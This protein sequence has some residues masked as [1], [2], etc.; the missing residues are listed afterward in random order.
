[1]RYKC[2][3]GIYA[4]IE[5]YGEVAVEF[6]EVEVYDKKVLRPLTQVL[7]TCCQASTKLLPLCPH[8]IIK[9]K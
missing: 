2:V 3:V 6:G 9:R 1:M 5:P 8:V 7:D 4:V